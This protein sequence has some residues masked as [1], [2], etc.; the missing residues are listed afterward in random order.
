MEKK[1]LD[2]NF[3]CDVGVYYLADAIR[4]RKE[5][6]YMRIVD[7][8]KKMSAKS[9]R[10]AVSVE[11][12]MRRCLKRSENEYSADTLDIAINKLAIIL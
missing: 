4:L 8:I 1:L 3:Y 7:I 6:R 9:G 11:T 2:M 12:A 5:N 10:S